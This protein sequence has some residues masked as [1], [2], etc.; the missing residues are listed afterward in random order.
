M[1]LYFIGVYIISP[2]WALADTKFLFQVE[3]FNAG[4]EIYYLQVT[5]QY[6]VYP[7]S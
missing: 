7:R 2:I 4:R 3:F 6:L 5:M 1:A